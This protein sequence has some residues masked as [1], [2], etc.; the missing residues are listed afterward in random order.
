[1]KMK[2]SAQLPL[3]SNQKGQS[4]TE[5]LILL[6]LIS[7]VSIAGVQSL[8]KAIHGKLKDAKEKINS[9]SVNPD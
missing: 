4:L 6:V 3:L 1:M 8:G 9:I 2:I 5:Y 7:V